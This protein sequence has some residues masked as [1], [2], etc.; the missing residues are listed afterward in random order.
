M[1][2][3]LTR[4]RALVVGAFVASL[5]VSLLGGSAQTPMVLLIPV[6]VGNL[7]VAGGLLVLLSIVRVSMWRV[8]LPQDSSYFWLSFLMCLAPSVVGPWLP[9]FL[10]YTFA[11]LVL[12]AAFPVA[13]RLPGISL[14]WS[15]V[16]LVAA[17]ALTAWGA[18]YNHGILV[19]QNKSR[20]SPQLPPPPQQ[21]VAQGMDVILVSIDTLRA[22]SIVG[23]REPAYELPFFDGM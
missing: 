12:V 3:F 6:M 16:V 18:A 20:S 4:L 23:P 10:T 14:V 2:A 1:I 7:M 11:G 8:H 17:P 15:L 22:D 9:E 5:I 13:N 21:P 19:A